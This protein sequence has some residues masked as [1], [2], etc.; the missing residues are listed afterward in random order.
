MFPVG[1]GLQP[2][3]GQNRSRL[4]RK[5]KSEPNFV[6]RTNQARDW[7]GAPLFPYTKFCSGLPPVDQLPPAGR[8]RA[9]SPLRAV[10]SRAGHHQMKPKRTKGP[11]PET[12]Q[13]SLELSIRQVTEGAPRSCQRHSRVQDMQ[14]RLLPDT[15]HST[16][17]GSRLHVVDRVMRKACCPSSLP[18]S[19]HL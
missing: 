17:A 3:G 13:S 5:Y 9:G 4:S 8:L 7:S 11:R 14:K 1:T 15:P 16:Y 10:G 6:T 18:W 2:H 19:H 12:D